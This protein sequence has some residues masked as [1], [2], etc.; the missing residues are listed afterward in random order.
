MSRPDALASGPAPADRDPLARW[1]LVGL[2]ALAVIV[3][4]V[5]LHL[6][7]RSLR[8]PGVQAAPEARYVGSERCAPCHKAAFDKWKGSHHQL[9]MQAARLGTVLGDFDDATFPLRGKTWKFFRR[10]ERFLVLAEGPDDAL[11]EY[12]VAY[13]FGIDPL[14]QYLIRFPGGRLQCL[15]V[16]WDKRAGRWFFLYPGK[17][18][19]P[20]DWLHWTRQAQNWNTMCADCHSTAVRK[21]YDVATDRFRTTWSEI[22]VGCEAC[23]GPGSL[24][25]AWAE[26]PAMARPQ[27]ENY[28]LR[29]RTSA[30]S[31]RELVDLCA[32]CHSRRAQIADQ[33]IPGTPLLDRY[34]PALLTPGT[35]CPDGQIL[36]EDYEYHSFLQSKMYANDVSCRDCHD[37]HSGKRRQDGNALCTRCHRADTYDTEAHHFHKRVHAGAPSAG[38]L[39]VSCHMPGRNYMVVHFRRDHSLRVPRPD[40][41][42]TLGTPNACNADGCHADRSV[43]WAVEK[44]D[45]WYGKKRKP[46]YGTALAAGSAR[47]PGAER[48]LAQLAQDPLRPAIARAT[49]LAFLARYPGEA[50]D[51]ALERA[52]ADEDPLVRHTAASNLA[53]PDPRRLAKALAPLLGDPALAVRAEAAARLAEIP[54]EL[55]SPAQRKAQAAAQADYVAIQLYMSDMPSGPYNLANLEMVE[56]KFVEAEEHYRR[57]LEIDDQFVAAKSNLALLLSRLGRNGEAA[58]LLREVVA[59]QPGDAVA[60]FNL[61]LLLAEEGKTAE[62]ERS[63]RAALKADPGMAGAAYNL[64]VLIA[65]RRPAEALTLSRRAAEARPDEPKYAWTLAY[66]QARTG[67]RLG[68]TR[69]LEALLQRFPGYADA[70]LLLADV[71]V[72]EGRSAEAEAALRRALALKDLADADRTRI[73]ARLGAAT[74]IPAGP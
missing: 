41:S 66:Y 20:T 17:N 57:A 27:V 21:R 3:L 25:A 69:T 53:P 32:P 5:P 49:A 28:A 56:G 39:C 48:E 24:H 68:A 62:A 45:T 36:D 33:G 59:A 58:L 8:G 52:L 60:A 10:G 37:V 55:L 34:L 31:G 46:H 67:D 44:C 74:R 22:M 16:A 64:A 19:P 35:F 2:A 50:T 11:H 42:V 1:R 14:Q 9:A 38:A 29:T 13:T 26:Q 72:R 51:A 4:S 30:I 18:I 61:G 6:T 12:E 40:L 43:R 54:A 7:L 73:A 70:T 15:S 47:R 63:L 71:L 65:E 23:H